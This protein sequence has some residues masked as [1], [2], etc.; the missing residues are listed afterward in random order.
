M[1]GRYQKFGAVGAS[2]RFAD[3]VVELETVGVGLSP[4]ATAARYAVG[5]D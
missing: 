1:I 5:T 3:F 4:N 2:L